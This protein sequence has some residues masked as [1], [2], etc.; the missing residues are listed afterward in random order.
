MPDVAH[1][2]RADAG[3]L[4]PNEAQKELTRRIRARRLDDIDGL[5]DTERAFALD[6]STPEH[7]DMISII[8]AGAGMATLTGPYGVGKT[9]AIMAA[10]NEAKRRGMTAHYTTMRDLLS[11]LREGFKPGPGELP[12]EKRWDLL[13]SAGVLAIDELDK[14]NATAWA[15]E[16]FSALVD[17]RWRNMR[18]QV[19]F[20]AMNQDVSGLPGDVEDRINDRNAV[21]LRM[22]GSSK[23]RSW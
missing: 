11:Y 15:Q 9:H 14:T 19:T 20:F 6:G 13:T 8:D 18:T 1:P 5:T 23:R 12:F 4:I 7:T 17:V 2:W 3:E 21:I 16:Q 22:T 10:I